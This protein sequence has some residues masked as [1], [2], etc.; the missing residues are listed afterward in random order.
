M[1]KMRGDKIPT[2]RG[3]QVK[4]SLLPNKVMKKSRTLVTTS[5]NHFMTLTHEFE[6]VGLE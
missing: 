5:A 3:E 1:Y 2:V 4:I 6:F